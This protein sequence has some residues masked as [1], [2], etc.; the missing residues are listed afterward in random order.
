MHHQ[1]LED[2]ISR[3]SITADKVQVELY[4]FPHW[5]NYGVDKK[6]RRQRQRVNKN[7]SQISQHYQISLCYRTWG[8]AKEKIRDEGSFSRILY[9][10]I[11]LYMSHNIL[12][13]TNG[14]D[15]LV[16]IGGK[17]WHISETPIKFFFKFPKSQFTENCVK[18]IQLYREIKRVCWR[19]LRPGHTP[20]GHTRDTSHILWN[21]SYTKKCCNLSGSVFFWF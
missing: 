19:W 11:L 2:C 8:R 3:V 5:E 10:C 14:T 21:H 15:V 9:F 13:K 7:N 20:A 18:E 17:V 1:H 6:H 16:L 12:M 4:W